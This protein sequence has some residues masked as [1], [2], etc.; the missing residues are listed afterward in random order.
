MYERNGVK[1]L[2]SP[3][4]GGGTHRGPLPVKLVVD[5]LGDTA[6]ETCVSAPDGRNNVRRIALRRAHPGPHY[7][8]SIWEGLTQTP[9]APLLRRA[10]LQ[11]WVPKS[12]G[13]RG[14]GSPQIRSCH[15]S[16]SSRPR[17]GG[18]RNRLKLSAVA[19]PLLPQQC[20]ESHPPRPRTR[21]TWPRTSFLFVSNSDDTYWFVRVILAS[22]LDDTFRVAVQRMKSHGKHCCKCSNNN[23]RS[24]SRFVREH[25]STETNM[26]THC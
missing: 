24:T 4:R 26:G 15:S 9:R 7:W 13:L 23:K 16:A 17:R 10:P 18:G 3:P 25:W 5:E 8:G 19:D 22:K 2:C 6:F 14:S 1:G 12:R 11:E 20:F 21:P